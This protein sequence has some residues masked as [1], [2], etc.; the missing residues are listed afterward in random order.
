MKPLDTIKHFKTL[1][2]ENGLKITPARLFILGILL[3]SKKPLSII[4][5]AKKLNTKSVDTA[6]LYRNAEAL[7]SLGLL[8]KI[9]I[10]NKRAYY[11]LNSPDH[12]HHLI[13]KNCGKIRDVKNCNLTI[14]EKELLNATGFSKITDH[15]LEFFGVCNQCD[16]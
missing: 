11:E 16:D 2:K 13:C 7:E 6:T 5:I 12:H 15:S 9:L 4:D 10:D 8:K 3:H 14:S 1:L